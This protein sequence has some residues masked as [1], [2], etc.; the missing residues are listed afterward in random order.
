MRSLSYLIYNYTTI[1]AV[2]RKCLLGAFRLR[3]YQKTGQKHAGICGKHRG[4][5]TAGRGGIYAF[6]LFATLQYTFSL[7]LQS[8]HFHHKLLFS[9][10]L[11]CFQFKAFV[12][13]QFV[14]PVFFSCLKVSGFKSSSSIV[15][16]KQEYPHLS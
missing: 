5:R 9:P 13:C 11:I 12:Y 16:S 7:H 8:A 1:I 4:G 10:D 15:I 2:F 6:R 14:I 3:I